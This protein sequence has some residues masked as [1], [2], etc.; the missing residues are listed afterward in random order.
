ME[1][2]FERKIYSNRDLKLQFWKRVFAFIL[3]FYLFKIIVG[4][5]LTIVNLNIKAEEYDSTNALINTV[6]QMELYQYF[7][8]IIYCSVLESSRWKGTFGKRFM[9]LAIN[10]M[11]L[12]R[13]SFGRALIRNLIKPFSIFSFFGIIIIDLTKKKQSLHDFL[14]RTR[15]VQY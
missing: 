15:I 4:L 9:R 13:I 12:E 2:K 5:L 10:D 11:K 1:I 14:V 7:L 6:T 8:F 3:D